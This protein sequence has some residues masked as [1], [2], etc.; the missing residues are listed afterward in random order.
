MERKFKGVKGVTDPE[1][2][3]HL[4]QKEEVVDESRTKRLDDGEPFAR[5]AW[6]LDATEASRQE[7][8]EQCADVMHA[9]DTKD[10]GCWPGARGC[11]RKACLT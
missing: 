1:W 5:W 10:H 11:I 9:E 3:A 8:L 2:L 6:N 7:A 4:V